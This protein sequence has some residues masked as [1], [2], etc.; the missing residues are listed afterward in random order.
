MTD[1]TISEVDFAYAAGLIDGEGHI[2]A[3]SR[4]G[5][6]RGRSVST[7]GKPYAHLD[8]RISMSL[9]VKEPL[10]WLLEKFGGTVYFKKAPKNKNWKDQWTW[11][12]MG[13][14]NKSA[15]LK[16]IIPFL[17][18]KQRQAILL[19]EYVQLERFGSTERRQEIIS[20]CSK[21]NRK[22][23]PVETNTPDCPETGQMIESD[24]VGDHE[25]A[26]VVTLTA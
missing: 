10:D 7:K 4:K 5:K 2:A 23:K 20:L 13:N 9:T 11:V 21:L 6:S 26:P 14:D 17:K 22:G 3:T 19:L 1:S 12:A 8:S 18:I 25:S 16:G 15:L 24:L